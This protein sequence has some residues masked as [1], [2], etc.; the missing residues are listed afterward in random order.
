MTQVHQANLVTKM[1]PYDPIFQQ[2]LAGFTAGLHQYSAGAQVQ[3]Q[4]YGVLYGVMQQQANLKAYVDMFCWTA[5]IMAACLPGA[6]L[7]RS[8]IT[9]GNVTIH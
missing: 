8:V 1:T 6:W 3:T 9:K 5:L 2:R 7:L 4:A